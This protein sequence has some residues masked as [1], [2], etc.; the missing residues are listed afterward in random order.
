M[1]IT[2]KLYAALGDLLPPEAR[3]NAIRIEVPEDA[4]VGDVLS[5]HKVPLESCHLMLINGHY[6][7]PGLAAA[8]PLSNGDTLA[9]WPPIAGG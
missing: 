9:V 1:K 4:T 7:K 5:R 6:R 2:L 3:E 8:E